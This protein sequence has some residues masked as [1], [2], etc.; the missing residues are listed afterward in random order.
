MYFNAD[1]Q[2][3]VLDRLHFALRSGGL[4]LLGK[5]E[6]LLS[7]GDLFQPLDPQRRF[8]AKVSLAAPTVPTPARGGEY[9]EIAHEHLATNVALRDAALDIGYAAR[10]GVD[11]HGRLVLAN[12]QA[13]A[14]FEIEGRDL[15][16]PLRDLEVS[17]RPADLRRAIA[18]GQE[19]GEATSL[20]A[21]EW[22]GRRVRSASS[23]WTCC[24]WRKAAS[25]PWSPSAT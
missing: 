7:H 24:P 14:M 21:L 19:M 11:H 22:H 15:E 4:L 13:R 8:F 25:A 3:H 16:R 5:A 9:A 12:A 1:T 6:K 18:R 10:L 20:R 17:Y 23:T 2:A